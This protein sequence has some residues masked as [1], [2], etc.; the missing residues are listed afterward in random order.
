MELL[1][2]P[3]P[4]AQHK[5]LNNKVIDA[6]ADIRQGK[7]GVCFRIRLLHLEMVKIGLDSLEEGQEE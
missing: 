6:V 7:R 2:L 3:V 1:H 4:L 5:G